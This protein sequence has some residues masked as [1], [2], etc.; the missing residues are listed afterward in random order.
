MVFCASRRGCGDS[1]R[2]LEHSLDTLKLDGVALLSNVEGVYLGDPALDPLFEELDRRG[3]VVHL[4]PNDLPP[5]VGS[6]PPWYP[7][8]VDLSFETT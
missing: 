8:L 4:H 6:R 3:T 7:Y 2:E 5:P 1:L